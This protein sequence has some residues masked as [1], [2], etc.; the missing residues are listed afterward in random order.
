MA[1]TNTAWTHPHL[2]NLFTSRARQ[3][4]NTTKV[5][6]ST[7]SSTID[8]IPEKETYQSGGTVTLSTQAIVSMAYGDDISDPTGL[9]RWRGQ[10]LRGND[11]KLFSVITAYRVC[12]Q[13]SIASVPIGSA[14][15]QEYEHFRTNNV[16]SPRPRKLIL[17]MLDSN[18]TLEDDQDLQA[19]QAECDLHD[20]HAINP[21]PSTF[22]GAD[23]R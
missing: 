16:K 13:G 10:T 5:S 11:K 15:S 17:V 14:F 3:H 23:N 20:L 22:I 4:L 1:V 18:G 2:R 9:G 6:F 21:A 8:P 12:R 7:V 19:L